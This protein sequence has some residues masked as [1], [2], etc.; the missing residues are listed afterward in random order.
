[1]ILRLLL[2]LAISSASLSFAY[3]QNRGEVKGLLQSEDEKE[4]LSFAT[5][6]A[7]T[8]EDTLL[9]DYVLSEDDGSFRIRRMPLNKKLRLIVSFLGYE[10]VKKDFVLTSE[11]KI[12][13]FGKLLMTVSS[14]TLEEVLVQG[15]RP[16]IIMKN[17]T[18]EFNAASFATR[19]GAT[20]EDLIKRLPG[21]VVDPQGNITANGRPV[22][23]V[24]VDGKDFFG[25]DPRIALRNLSSDMIDKVQLADD[26][27]EDPQ[28]LLADDEVD[29]V[30]NLKLK[31]DLKLNLF[32]KAYAGGG[33][34]D[35]FEAGGIANSFRDTFQFSLL[36]YYNN[37]TPNNLSMNEVL[38]L[39]GIRSGRRGNS[40]YPLALLGGA[41][42]NATLGEA[43]FHLQYFYSRDELEFGSKSFQE[44]TIRP[45]SIFLYDT[46]DMGNSRNEGHNLRGGMKWKI[47]TMTQ[48]H[49]D[50]GMN[51]AAGIR[52]SVNEKSSAFNDPENILQNFRTGEEPK[53][54]G[55]GIN[56]RVYF[57]RKLNN[58]GRNVTLRSSFS[59][60]KNHND[61][62]SSFS[63]TYFLKNGADSA[64]YFDQLK[65]RF[66]DNQ[67]F[68]VSL[69]YTEPMAENWYVDVSGGYK[70]SVRI[71]NIETLQ[72]YPDDEDWLFN[73]DLSRDF[74]RDEHEVE[75]TA[76]I[77][78]QK[79]KMQI[80]LSADYDY[81]FYMNHFGEED[82]EF[83]ENYRF[84]SPR[85]RIVFR[86]W[87]L[88]YRY[89]YSTPD[90]NQLH[91]VRNNTNPLL[92]VEGN[93]DLTPVRGHQLSLSK[94]SYARQWKYRVSLNGDFRSESIV[95][96][97]AVDP[98]GVTYRRPVNFQGDA[99]N[100]RGSGG[101]GR[102]FERENHK[103]SIN[104]DANTGFGSSPFFINSQEGISNRLN[105]GGRLTANYNL[106]DVLDFAPRYSID[107]TKNRYEKVDYRDV[108][109]VNHSFAGSLTLFLPWNMEF[110]ND[111]TYSYT[112]QVTPGF[113]KSSVLWHAAIHKKILPDK[114]MTLRISAYDLLDQ[115]INFYRSVS[116]NTITDR[117]H[118]TLTRYLMASVIYDFRQKSEKKD[119]GF[120][121]GRRGRT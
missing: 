64:V 26:R 8:A 46:E 32:G 107:H 60:N 59:K 9:L 7:Y 68:N 12:K 4:P 33:T 1:M 75:M 88:N 78:Y 116:Y 35:R 45:D 19:D 84:I 91:P 62:L 3:A 95:N 38:R 82:S 67:S 65:T 2:F 44:Q 105:V 93:P 99:Y 42:A 15:E 66:T 114:K 14:Q 86:R 87:R 25:G 103:L 50:I 112:P 100:I 5:V 101:I 36:G 79:D 120:G 43:K 121:S 18:I 34:R 57:N 72:Q 30:I 113:R 80:N 115:N 69:R 73:N 77:R 22:T 54:A 28:H 97:S 49:I 119:G 17:D 16:P 96:V 10:A 110:H 6:S 71:N 37:L 106:L 83:K 11:E 111:V 81:L 58:G 94:F 40:G 108:D 89:N 92:E 41:N 90:I 118:I 23:K 63:R 51:S 70:P 74:R 61:L 24:R 21:I 102:T 29:Q 53:S 55:S 27:E 76:G 104:V 13:D 47:D 20:V 109:V 31:K 56:T 52:S 117:E 85:L 39:G 98:G 48:L